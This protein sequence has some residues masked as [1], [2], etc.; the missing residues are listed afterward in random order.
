M[1]ASP[2]SAT[3]AQI[4]RTLATLTLQI[5]ALSTPPPP[6][7]FAHAPPRLARQTHYIVNNGE[8]VV[9]AKMPSPIARLATAPCKRPLYIVFDF[10]TNGLGKTSGIRVVQVGA[11][12]LDSDFVTVSA[13]NEFVNPLA[14]IDPKAV[15]VHGIDPAFANQCAAWDDVGTRFNKWM[16]D[17]RHDDAQP[18][19]MLAHNGKRFDA[20]M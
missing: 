19:V 1:M 8:E 15:A 2:R 7:H 12:A 6:P 3:L 14:A 11:Q 9:T 20:R 10:E 13:F 16:D 18:L 17:V 4:T 5:E